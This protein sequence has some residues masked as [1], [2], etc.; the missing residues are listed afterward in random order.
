MSRGCE[1]CNGRP[2]WELERVGDA[3]GVW[4]CTMCL[5][6]QIRRLQRRWEITELRVRPF[7][8]VVRVFQHDDGRWRARCFVRPCGA[9]DLAVAKP[10]CWREAQSMA[11][12]HAQLWHA[13]VATA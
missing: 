12:L 10:K 7:R 9:D 13:K 4:A 11:V 2:D 3:V 6:D 8:R 5:P 1:G